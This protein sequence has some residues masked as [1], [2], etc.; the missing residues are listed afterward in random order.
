MMYTKEQAA[1]L[2]VA[3]LQVAGGGLHPA[4]LQMANTAAQLAA[5]LPGASAI[6]VCVGGALQPGALCPLQNTGLAAVHLFLHPAL[7]HYRTEAY[8]QVVAPFLAQ[9]RPHCLLVGATPEG[10]A[11]APALAVPLCTGVTADCTELALTPAFD[12]LQTRPAFGGNVMAQIVTPG[13]R[14]QIATVRPGVMGL[15]TARAGVEPVQPKVV[16]HNVAL[17]APPTQVAQVATAEAEAPRDL[18]FAVGGGLAAQEDIARFEEL[19][20]AAGATLMCSRSIVERGW[21]PQ[22][23]QI[24]LSGNSV[25]PKLLVAFGISGSVQFMAGIGGAHRL[26]AVNMDENAPLL[27]A[28]DLPLVGDLYAVAEALTHTFTPAGQR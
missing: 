25:A 14:P 26:I 16:H 20:Q 10:R 9:H 28:A 11:L 17:P 15:H 22:N 1:P 19:A 21:L 23:R 27:R 12:L 8:V 18:I 5:G 13:A 24:G 2:L 7:A 4:S 3:F 6:G